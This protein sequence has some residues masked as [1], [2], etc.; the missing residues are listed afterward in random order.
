VLTP[1]H[2]LGLCR[3]PVDP[4]VRQPADQIDVVARK[5]LDDTDIA[6][7]PREWAGARCRDA[8]EPPELAVNDPTPHLLQRG[9]VP[10]D[11]TNGT[12]HAVS[13]ADLDDL[14]RGLARRR[15]RLLDQQGN[16]RS[17]ELLGDR[18]MQVGRDGDDREVKRTGVQQLV[19]G[20]KR[21]S[22]GVHAAVAVAVRID[23]ACEPDALVGLHEPRMVTAN[24]PKPND[25]SG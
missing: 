7:P 23:G 25:G 3:D 6:Y 24:H 16:T 8:V 9:V 10:L 13:C 11:V 22:G 21:S 12:V 14:D 18:Q 20:R 15:Q 5:V 4:G 1:G 2:M 17:G 19:D